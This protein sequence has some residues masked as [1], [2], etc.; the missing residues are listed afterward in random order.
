MYYVEAEVRFH[1]ITLTIDGGASQL[2]ALTTY[3]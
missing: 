3:P 2:H 1:N